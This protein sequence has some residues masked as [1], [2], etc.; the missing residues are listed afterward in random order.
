MAQSGDGVLSHGKI[1]PEGVDRLR[2]LIYHEMRPSY[3]FNQEVTRDGIRHFAWGVGDDNPL[4]LEP[5]H[6]CASVYGAPVAPPSFL[7]TIHPTFV[8][9]GLAG[10]HGFHAGT[11]WT[12]LRPVLVGDTPRTTTWVHDVVEKTGRMGGRS[13]IVYFRTVY[14]TA[15]NEVIADVL[16]WSMR[17]ERDSTRKRNK[18]ADWEPATWTPEQMDRLE[19]EMVAEELRGAEPRYWEDVSVGDEIPALVKGPL[20][21]SDMIAWYVGSSPLYQPA[22]ELAI[23]HF[24]RHP[25]WGYRAKT[26]ARESGIRVHEDDRAARSAGVPAQYDLGVQR[27]QWLIQLL[28][29]W[30]GDGGFVRQCNAEYRAFNFFGD[31]QWLRGRVESKRVDANGDHV[32]A[33]NVWSENQRGEVTMPGDAEVVLPT[34]ADPHGAVTRRLDARLDHDAYLGDVVPDLV[35]LESKP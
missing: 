25:K 29:N 18:H 11:R 30:A 7:Y 34:R 9:V 27:N 28:T 17:V 14:S 12:F 4:W 19:D 26:G 15:A 10:V 3:R 23:K 24:R 6:A 31:V 1:T 8:Q 35:P 22:H 13:V 16:T 21:L 20:N 32:V 2:G 5:E 33:L